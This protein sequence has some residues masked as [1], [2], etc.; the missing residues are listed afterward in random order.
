M[1]RKLMTSCVAI[2]A[3]SVA[4]CNTLGGSKRASGGLT[5]YKQQHI[6][7][8]ITE[9]RANEG[10]GVYQEFIYPG[11]EKKSAA[12]SVAEE[13]VLRGVVP[14]GS[15]AKIFLTK[16]DYSSG[17][18][19]LLKDDKK[20]HLT[21]IAYTTSGPAN[22][23]QFDYQYVLSDENNNLAYLSIIGGRDKKAGRQF[24]EAAV[25]V[26]DNR[27][28]DILRID[29]GDA[30]L[31]AP[32]YFSQLDSVSA[33]LKKIG[34]MAD[35][36]DSLATKMVSLQK[37]IDELKV[38]K[39]AKISSADAEVAR[40]ENNFYAT[41]EEKLEAKSKR[42]ADFLVFEE[43]ITNNKN[44]LTTAQNSREQLKTQA[45]DA[46]KAVYMDRN[47]ALLN[48]ARYMQSP[49]FT[50]L[51]HDSQ[52]SY[53]KSKERFNKIDSNLLLAAQRI[54]GESTQDVMKDS[55]K[56]QAE[57]D[58]K[59]GVDYSKPIDPYPAFLR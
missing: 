40:L 23:D 24:V 16:S 7:A 58:L 3:I 4:G 43:K 8:S 27:M 50:W 9:S 1:N 42:D 19:E 12:A 18:I 11:Q 29:L 5:E 33:Q 15:N 2:A 21:I 41:A 46:L 53:L 57:L 6:V 31:L 39:Q 51:P 54:L 25:L 45:T 26:A 36:I 13:L 37:K 28:E 20:E 56:A 44:K 59:L 35:E 30:G 55:I 14:G 49:A 47:L 10:S 22:A 34:K 48:Y 38:K 32:Q 17:Y 52:K